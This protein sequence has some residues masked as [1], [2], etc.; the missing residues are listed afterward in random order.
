MG[1]GFWHAWEGDGFPGGVYR[2]SRSPPSEE[3]ACG[4]HLTSYTSPPNPTPSISTKRYAPGSDP[5]GVGGGC[6]DEM[7]PVMG[8]ATPVVVNGKGNNGTYKV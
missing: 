8:E 5:V 3:P 2:P 4:Y 7:A 6:C 1:F